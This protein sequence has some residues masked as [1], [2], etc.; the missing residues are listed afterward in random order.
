RQCIASLWFFLSTGSSAE[1]Q[2][3]H[4]AKLK[5]R[6]KDDATANTEPNSTVQPSASPV[7]TVPAAP[8]AASSPAVKKPH[9]PVKEIR[10]GNVKIAIWANRTD[11]G[12]RH[13]V[14]IKRLYKDDHTGKWHD[15]DVF[16]IHDLAK[17]D[18]AIRMAQLWIW[19]HGRDDT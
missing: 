14:R 12:I 3:R 7:A 4:M 10:I 17:L 18:M 19:Q 15:S 11:R 8:A 9:Q 2:D 6:T 16:G 13:G 5:R 1:R